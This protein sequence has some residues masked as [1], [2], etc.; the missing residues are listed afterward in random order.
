MR[1]ARSNRP[2][3]RRR[4]RATAPNVGRWFGAAALA[5][6][7][8]G[9]AA[10]PGTALAGPTVV[11]LYTSQGCSSCPPADAL[12]G[13]LTGR[14]DLIPLTFNVDY[15]NYLG[16]TDRFSKPEYSK[17][18]RAY[19]MA[20]RW[21]DSLPI[22]TPQMVVHGADG[23]IGS[24]RRDV[25]RA[26]S[27]ADGLEDHA[28]IAINRAGDTLSIDVTPLAGGAPCRVLL[29]AFSGPHEEAIGQGENR[30]RSVTYHNV[31]RDVTD[32]GEWR[33]GDATFEAEIDPSMRGY[34]VLLQG[35]SG[36]PIYGAGKILF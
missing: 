35:P 18:Q 27:A 8:A 20:R 12:L 16:W 30:G 4:D 11:E 10:G 34:A 5:A 15:W 9:T 28:E 22:Y 33:G 14:D 23:V 6:A 24:R 29:V 32:L 3:A 31:V 36:G 19:G 1:P 21:G 7:A 2:P 17:R 26:I 25:A 13:E